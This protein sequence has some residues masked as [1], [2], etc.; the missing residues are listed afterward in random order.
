MTR[1]EALNLKTF[2]HYCTCGGFAH[3]MNGRNPADPHMDYCKQK[4]EYRE[5][6]RLVHQESEQKS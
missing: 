3:S 4:D 2:S 6:Y 5:W 1:E